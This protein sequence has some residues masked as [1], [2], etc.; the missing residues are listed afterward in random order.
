MSR[1]RV[2]TTIDAPPARVWREVRHIDRHVDW[3]QDAVAIRFTSR[4]RS[5]VGATFDCETR[6]GPIRLTDRMEVTAWDDGRVIGVRHVGLV[7]G[8]GR[9]TLRRARGGRTRFT[10]TERL[11]FPWWLGGPLGAQAG[12]LVLRH[13]WARNLARLKAV[14]EDAQP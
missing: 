7:T 13:I 2:S 6:V 10:W 12:G 1:I 8:E 4:R 5:G 11:V 9:F 14:V 3:M